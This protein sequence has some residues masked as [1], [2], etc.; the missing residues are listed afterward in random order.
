MVIKT[1]DVCRKFDF[2]VHKVCEYMER[3]R[4][5]QCVQPY[6]AMNEWAD[7]LK[8]CDVI[9]SDLTDK[10]VKYPSAL[11]TEHDKVMY[12]KKIIENQDYEEK[13]QSVVKEYGEKYSYKSGKFLI[14]YPKTL[15]DLFEEGRELNHCVGSY[16]DSIKDGDSI[17]LF[18]RKTD[19]P[20]KPYYTMEVN[21]VYN[22]VTQVHGYSNCVPHVIKNKELIE[23]IK[24]WANKNEINYR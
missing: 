24:K 9:G 16:G 3:V 5:S 13:F 12:K 7:Y 1:A 14:T 11:R 6:T 18:I 8:A 4:V 17:V 15:N 22:A 10:R 23:F 21:P 19:T 20:D 2:T